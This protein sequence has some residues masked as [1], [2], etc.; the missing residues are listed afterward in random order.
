MVDMSKDMRMAGGLFVLIA[1]LVACGNDKSAPAGVDAGAGNDQRIQAATS[2]ANGNPACTAIHPFYWEIGDA[3][4]ALVGG[5]A[6]S[7]GAIAPAANTLML[8][9][10]A[11]KWIFGTYVV[12]LRAGNLTDNDIAALTMRSG[13]TGLRYA[14]CIKLLKAN[15]D[16]ET[17]HECFVDSNLT[18]RNNDFDASLVGS[19]HYNGGHFQW[20]AD[21]DLGLGAAN[22]A[23]LQAALSAQVGSDWVFSYDSP[24]LAAGVQTSAGGYAIFLRKILKGE[25]RM[26]DLLGTSAVCTNPATCPEASYAPIPGTESWHYSLGHWVED[27]SVVGDGAFS[28]PGAFGFYP[29]IDASKTIYGVLARHE[30]VSLTSDDPV[31]VGSV[32]C[33]RAIRRAWAT[34]TPQ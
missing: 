11:S 32:Q 1:L 13:Y 20:L 18:G 19:F 30:N 28:S 7:D 29:W 24:Q 23:S 34:G 3:N 6:S 4:G 14:S 10:S 33:G 15:Q 17:V 27:D 8:I 26:R 22:N 25:L 16:A 9:A 21:G 31:A 5:T 2:T 12:E